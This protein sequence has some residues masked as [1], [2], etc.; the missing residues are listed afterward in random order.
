[1]EEVVS[2]VGK[3]N[4]ISEKVRGRVVGGREFGGGKTSHRSMIF[5]FIESSLILSGEPFLKHCD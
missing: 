2:G 4:G 3:N 5:L 1:L